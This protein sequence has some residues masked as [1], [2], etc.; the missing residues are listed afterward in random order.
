[1]TFDG[2]F[3]DAIVFRIAADLNIS[4]KQHMFAPLLD[5]NEQFQDVSFGDAVFVLDPGA[6]QDIGDLGDN[7]L[8][9]DG[10]EIALAKGFEDLGW[11]SCRV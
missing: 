10:E 2:S 11:K 6:T 5:E 8:G 7:R 9:N 1:V 3:D 4:R